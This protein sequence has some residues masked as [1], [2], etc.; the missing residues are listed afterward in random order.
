MEMNQGITSK[1]ERFLSELQAAQRAE[2]VKANRLILAQ[3]S[4]MIGGSL[5]KKEPPK[6]VISMRKTA[7]M[8]ESKIY[9]RKI[10]PKKAFQPKKLVMNPKNLTSKP[11]IE[12]T[13]R[14]KSKN[15]IEKVRKVTQMMSAL[16]D[17]TY[18]KKFQKE[19][20]PLKEEMSVLS[21]KSSEKAQKIMRYKL[22][23][24][25]RK[26]KHS[27]LDTKSNG[28]STE[29]TNT[30]EDCK[31]NE[32]PGIRPRRMKHQSFYIT[33][34][35]GTFKQSVF[36]SFHGKRPSIGNNSLT[37]LK[38]ASR[39]ETQPY[40]QEA[41]QRNGRSSFH[42]TKGTELF[43]TQ[44]SSLFQT[45]D[46]ACGVKKKGDAQIMSEKAQYFFQEC[47]QVSDK[48]Q[49]FRV[50]SNEKLDEMGAKLKVD[51]K[52]VSRYLKIAKFEETD[53]KKF[54]TFIHQRHFKHELI[55]FLS[56]QIS[57]P[58]KCYSALREKLYQTKKSQQQSFAF[59]SNPLKTS[60]DFFRSQNS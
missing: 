4:S 39:A 60:K 24:G 9:E 14:E 1:G 50:R 33:S 49:R 31:Q 7:K 25:Q 17:D 29:L 47:K 18:A 16:L 5:A 58:Q 53:K 46:H 57:D 42:L 48:M 21:I 13:E 15:E 36:G 2:M 8:S 20:K 41:V 45:T 43:N 19:E 40:L 26:K 30:L 51:T 6:P 27:F 55:R 52:K 34:P 35:K 32:T 11:A 54:D 44:G 38:F 3:T 23:E 10:K 37:L 59:P 22:S 56:A 28:I 12:E